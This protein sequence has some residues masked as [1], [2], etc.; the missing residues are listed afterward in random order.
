MLLY[1]TSILNNMTDGFLT[2][3]PDGIVNI[4][5][6]AFLLMFNLSEKEITEKEYSEIYAADLT[7]LIGK[8]TSEKKRRPL[9]VK[10]PLPTEE[11]AGQ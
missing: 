8:V 5:N 2:I 6:P 1:E 4:S 3:N 7:S 10:Y 11:S 9:W